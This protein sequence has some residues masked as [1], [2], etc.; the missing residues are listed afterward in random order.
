MTTL[1]Y[2]QFEPARFINE[3]FPSVSLELMNAAHAPALIHSV[4]INDIWR[5][6][7]TVIPKP[8]AVE[9]YIDVALR[10]V[11]R[12]YARA[13]VI[14][15]AAQVVGCTRFFHL[16]L[17]HYR[18]QIGGTW[19]ASH[20]RHTGVNRAAK[21]LMLREAFEVM[22]LQRVE[23]TVHP[24]NTLSRTA[25]ASLGAKFEGV[26]R[27]YLHVQGQAHDAAMYSVVREDWLEIQQRVRTGNHRL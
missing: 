26:L 10:D 19:L 18:V 20:A 5:N 17:Q 3:Q 11:A 12:G 22:Q 21:W 7:F 15:S 1:L 24:E 23:F 25:L 13:F 8:D 16:N 27:Q 2:P 4:S 9:H 6:P 14:R